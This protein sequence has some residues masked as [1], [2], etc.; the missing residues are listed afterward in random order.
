MRSAAVL[1]DQPQHLSQVNGLRRFEA[2]A[3]ATH[4]AAGVW[5][6]SSPLIAHLNPH[7]ISFSNFRLI[8]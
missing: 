2:A 1:K 4:T 3:G 7:L 6:L 8:P 5:T